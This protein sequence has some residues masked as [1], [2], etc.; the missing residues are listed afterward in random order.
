MEKHCGKGK[1]WGQGGEMTQAYEKK[2]IDQLIYQLQ[3]IFLSTTYM[4]G[5]FLSLE[6]QFFKKQKI[7]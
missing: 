4:S 3:Q 7:C 2:N 1:G 5:I 6:L